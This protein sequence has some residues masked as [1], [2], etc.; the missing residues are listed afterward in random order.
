[1]WWANCALLIT[2]FRWQF[3]QFYSVHW[4]NHFESISAWAWILERTTVAKL[5]FH[6]QPFKSRL[7]R[8]AVDLFPP[9]LLFFSM[10]SETKNPTSEASF[11]WYPLVRSCLKI[12]CDLL[13]CKCFGGKWQNWL[14]QSK[15]GV[16]Y[17]LLL[18]YAI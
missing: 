8:K 6:C 4:T 7:K 9:E 12:F 15:T 14:I 13:I 17:M 16:I 5:N 11:V 2:W 3:L 10:C 1:M 18:G